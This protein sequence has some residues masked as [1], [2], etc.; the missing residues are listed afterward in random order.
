MNRKLTPKQRKFAN[1]YI[2]SGNAEQSAID[3]GYSSAYAR[4]NAHKLVANVSIKSYI[5]ERM[6]EL[7]SQKIMSAKEAIEL[8][9]SIARGEIK[10]TVIV[11]T[12]IGAEEVQKEADFKTRISAIREILKRY[13][14]SDKLT[15]VQIRKANAEADIAAYK[16]KLLT[17]ADKG[18]RT[19]IIDDIE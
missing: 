9:S 12:P 5:D 14:D 8:L 10:E 13:P 1:E 4:G 6:Q 19:V 16:A 7:E 11:S 3:A 18:D 15:E 17:E 2:K